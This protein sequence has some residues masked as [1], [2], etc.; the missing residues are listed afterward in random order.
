MNV[1]NTLLCF[2]VVLVF[3]YFFFVAIIGTPKREDGD[4]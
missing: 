2:C 3:Y 4:G 1:L